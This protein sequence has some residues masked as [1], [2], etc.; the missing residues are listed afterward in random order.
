MIGL[1][2]RCHSVSG[3]ARAHDDGDHGDQPGPTDEAS[4]DGVKRESQHADLG[5]LF[6]KRRATGACAPK[7]A[8]IRARRLGQRH[9]GQRVDGKPDKLATQ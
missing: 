5:L 4:S 1:D 9:R 7:A 2:E 6:I 3:K 8:E